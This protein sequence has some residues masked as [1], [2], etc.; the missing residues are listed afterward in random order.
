MWRRAQPLYLERIY[1]IKLLY[2]SVNNP[3]TLLNNNMKLEFLNHCLLQKERS[4]CLIKWLSKFLILLWNKWKAKKSSR[5]LKIL[6]KKVYLLYIL[7]WFLINFFAQIA[8]VIS[9]CFLCQSV[10]IFFC[11]HVIT[12]MIYILWVVLVCLLYSR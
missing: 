12:Y 1:R 10:T 4:L 8:Q 5:N 6:S 11:H 2:S 9:K 7:Q 3:T